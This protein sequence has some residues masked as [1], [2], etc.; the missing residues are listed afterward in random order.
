MPDLQL[1]WKV[2][3]YADEDSALREHKAVR[4]IKAKFFMRFK[5]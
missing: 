5:K 4:K 1:L 3:W 2:T